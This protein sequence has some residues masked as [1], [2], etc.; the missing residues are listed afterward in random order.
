[1]TPQVQSE[2]ILEIVKAAA[3]HHP[4]DIPSA[5]DEAEMA[6]RD[7]PD[8]E[9]LISALLRSA[10]QELVYDAR[11]ALNTRIKRD[12]GYY[13]GPAK[14]NGTSDG[15]QKVYESVYRYCIGSTTLGE[16]KGEDIPEIVEGEKAKAQGHQFNAELLEWLEAQGVKGEKRVREVVPE[17]KLR[18]NF[19]RIYEAVMSSAARVTEPV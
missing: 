12:A 5:V 13:G 18:K 6:I 9:A 14:V 19:D 16:L 11:H 4:G 10:I 1:M 8:F 17:K 7:L 3:E 2:S 15:V